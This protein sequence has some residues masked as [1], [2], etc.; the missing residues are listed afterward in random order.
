METR[1]ILVVDDERNIRETLTQALSPLGMPVVCAINGEE[2]L[3]Q[4][5]ETDFAVI[6]LDLKLPGK[7]GLDVLRGLRDVRPHTPVVMVTAHATV[8]I[9][10]DAMKLGAVDLVQK[11][12]G[13]EEIREVVRRV[14]ARAELAE[15]QADDYLSLI[16]LAYK[17]I[18]ERRFEEA[19]QLVRRAMA[20]DP[21]QP[22]AYNLLGALLEMGGDW[23]QAQKF[24]RAALDIAPGYKPARANLERTT[25]FDKRGVIHLLPP[26]KGDGHP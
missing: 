21:G 17:R 10:V 26:E 6:L 2:A 18:T 9:A 13:T 19:R 25:S 5:K 4:M 22:E 24:Y 16:A 3:R 15:D 11:P 20:A 1:P 23:L 14:L 8:G 7:D 12:F